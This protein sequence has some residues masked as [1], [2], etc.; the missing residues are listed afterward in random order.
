LRS[1][2]ADHPTDLTARHRPA[3]VYRLY[4]EPAEARRWNFLDES[5]DPAET[6]AFEARH[7]DPPR[8]M[9]ALCR[10]APEDHAPTGTARARLAALREPALREPALR[11][12][13][14]RES[15]LREPA[16]R[17]PAVGGDGGPVTWTDPYIARRTG[18]R[19]RTPRLPAPHLPDH[20]RRP[21]LPGRDRHDHHRPPVPVKAS[22]K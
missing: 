3:T 12:P 20:P 7:P 21:P 10:R 13:A 15:P 22:T 18:S 11:E 1:L 14:L 2:I 17:E 9:I 4:G 8:R 5:A 19:A 6:A 16:L